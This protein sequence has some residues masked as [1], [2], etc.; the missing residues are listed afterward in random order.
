MKERERR[1]AHQKK[2]QQDANDAC[3][4]FV[5]PEFGTDIRMLNDEGD[6]IADEGNAAADAAAG[7]FEEG[8]ADAAGRVVAG[9]EARA[10]GLDARAV[11][12]ACVAWASCGCH[13]AA[14][15]SVAAE[16]AGAGPPA[17]LP[18]V[19]LARLALSFH[20]FSSIVAHTH[21]AC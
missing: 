13:T 8:D 9:L 6:D 18:F 16:A 17:T 10:R 19:H 3:V 14:L 11:V 20:S 4:E 1:V 21:D 12:A 7:L 5:A 2:F 15:A